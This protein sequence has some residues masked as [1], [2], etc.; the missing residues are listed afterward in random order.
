M[1]L[2]RK[3]FISLKKTLIRMIENQF[4]ALRPSLKVALFLSLVYFS[5]R[6]ILN[7]LENKSIWPLLPIIILSFLLVWLTQTN[8]IRPHTQ[9]ECLDCFEKYYY[10]YC[11]IHPEIKASM[12]PTIKP[13]RKNGRIWLRRYEINIYNKLKGTNE[14]LT[15]CINV[16]DGEY[17]LE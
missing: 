13:E 4:K 9:D 2:K 5:A 17:W 8:K 6:F 14:R 3:S 12:L 16:W 15:W 11:S 10:H 7:F 1:I